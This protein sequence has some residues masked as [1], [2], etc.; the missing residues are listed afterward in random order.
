MTRTELAAHDTIDWSLAAVAL[1][2]RRWSDSLRRG[3]ISNPAT[4]SL[5]AD[6]SSTRISD[7]IAT[8]P[9][10]WRCSMRWPMLARCASWGSCSVAGRNRYGSGACDAINTYYGRGDLPMG[11]YRRYGRR[12]P[13]RNVYRTHCRSTRSVFTTTSSINR[14]HGR[15]ILRPVAF[16]TRQ[17]RHDPDRR[18]SSWISA[19]P[20]RPARR[21]SLS[22]QKVERWVAMGLGGWN[23][24]QMGMSA[25]S[26]ELFAKWP[27]D[28]Y[29]SPSG[30]DVVTGHRLLPQ[31]PVDNPVREAY[32]LWNDALVEGPF[33]LGSGGRAGSGPPAVVPGGAHGA[34]GASRRRSLSPGIP[35]SII[36]DSTWFV[37]TF[38]QMN[39]RRSSKN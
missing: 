12:G 35:R 15:P 22:K 8:T 24:E 28:L 10:R 4:S 25:Y 36:R 20:A 6:H 2:W 9:V 5:P 27:T 30:E 39:S 29:V 16:S 18:T 21:Q 23:F 14:R 7:R 38:P 32:R 11:Q 31:T 13:S 3:Q 17:E 1:G 19:L 37:P 34:S 26:A 33:E